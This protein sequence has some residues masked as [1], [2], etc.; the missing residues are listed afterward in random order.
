MNKL[1]QIEKVV[2]ERLLKKRR[3]SLAYKKNNKDKVKA[4]S[5]RRYEKH[6]E[7]IKLKTAEYRE[8]TY[9]NIQRYGLSKE[10]YLQMVD[11]Q[12]N[13][14]AIC[15]EEESSTYRK[16]KIKKLSVDHCHNTGEVRGL[17]CSSCNRGIGYLRDN[18]DLLK[19]AIN[20]LSK[21]NQKR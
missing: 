13:K 5:K 9:I 17:L 7:S 2:D 6:K 4:Q 16:V 12:G 20:Y 3:A 14:C 10:S 11:K 18:V 15:N 1:Q 21:T 19:N 8:R